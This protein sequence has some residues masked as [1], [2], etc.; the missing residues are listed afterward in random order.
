MTEQIIQRYF[1]P[2]R[3]RYRASPLPAFLSWWGGELA[4]LIPDRLRKRMMPPKPEVWIV[5]AASGGGDLRI[6]RPGTPPERMDVFGAGEDPELLRGR[7]KEILDQFDDGAPEVRM[8]LNEDHVLSVP[9]TLPTAVEGNLDQSLGYQL[10]QLTP[11]RADQV[12]YS[13][14]ILNRDTER[15]RLEVEMRLVPKTVWEPIRERLAVIGIA[16]N[17]LDA[18]ESQDD[19]PQP[20]GFNLLP[21]GRRPHYVHA[22]A[23]LNWS[24]AGALVLLLALVM[25]QSLYLRGRSVDALE[26]E[27]D[28]LRAEAR[29]VMDLQ[30]QL[31]DALLAA[32][33]L[34]ERRR[35]Q[36]VNLE[37][38]AEL[39]RILPDDIWLQQYRL[40]GSE[41]YFQGLAEGSQRLIELVNESDLIADAEFRGSVT[42]DRATGMERFQADAVVRVPETTDGGRD[43]AAPES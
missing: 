38:L 43:A 29:E 21:E 9:V 32:N 5:P 28:Q 10:D 7:W 8:C 39:T 20:A 13:H 36:P 30:Q 42:V 25:V 23:R 41:L 4:S 16:P 1:G 18:V 26:A 34:A 22:R 17:V 33:F 24:L 11:F 35:R 3:A 40:Q 37:V 31:E 19:P 27:A 6:W 14:R 15:G 2:V 12:L